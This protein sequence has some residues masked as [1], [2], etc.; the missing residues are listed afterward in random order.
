MLKLGTFLPSSLPSIPSSLSS[1]SRLS[2]PSLRT[3]AVLAFLCLTS[4]ACSYK[5]YQHTVSSPA[6]TATHEVRKAQADNRI[7]HYTTLANGLRVLLISDPAADK[8]AA[9]L[10]VHV[11]SSDDPL[12]RAGLAHFLEHMLFLG[13]EKYPDASEYQAFISENGG[14]HNAYTSAEHTNYFFDVNASKLEEALDRFAQFFVAPLFDEVYVD[15]ERKAVHSEYQAKIKDDYRRGYDVY[16]H[17]M[18]PDHPYSKFSVGSL[19]TLADRP[20]DKVRDDLLDFYQKHYSSDQMTLVV[21]GK[22]SIEE[23]QALVEPRFSPIPQRQVEQQDQFIPLF[24]PGSLPMEVVSNPVQDLRQM[25]MIFP[26]PS[27]KPYYQE[28]PL[29]YL[30]FLLGHEGEGSV[31][32]VL[33]QKGWAES[34]S[35]GG[36]DAGVGNATFHIIVTLTDEGLRHRAE[37]RSLVFHALDVIRKEGVEAWRYAEEQQLGEIAF[38]F[39]ENGRA[40]STV[41]QLADQMHEYPISEVISAPYTYKRFDAKLIHQYLEKMTP[42]NLYVSTVAPGLPT[43]KKSY[44][45]NV[46]YAVGPLTEKPVEIAEELTSQYQLPRKNI[47]IPSNIELLPEE[48]Q[49]SDSPAVWPTNTQQL[50][51]WAQQDLSFGVP[52]ADILV[53]VKLPEVSQSVDAA[54]MSHL[55]I[56]MVNDS[57]NE[58]SYPALIAGLSYSVSPNSRGFDIS[59]RGYH[60]KMGVLLDMLTQRLRSPV[61]QEQRFVN[62]R[63]EL[64]R[65]LQNSQKET[66]FRQLL[67][68]LPVTLFEPYHSD[69]AIAASVAKISFDDLNTFAAR[70]LQGSHMQALFYGNIS[71]QLIGKWQADISRLLVDGELTLAH[72]KV[73][74]LPALPEVDQVRTQSLHVDHNDKAVVLYAQGTTDTMQDQAKMVLIRQVLDASFYNQLRTEQ[75]LGY[76]VFLTNMLIKDVPGSAFVV[77]SPSASVAQ[78]QQAITT[79]IDASQNAI[80]EDLSVF[81]DS[82]A[83][84]LLEK[85]QQLSAKASRFWQ[86]ILKGDPSFSYRKR[87]VKEI[88]KVTPAELRDYYQR[89]LLS[90][91][92]LLWFVADKQVA[93]D[94]PPLFTDD[95]PFY[96]YP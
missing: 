89:T 54:A 5:G 76:I 20:G 14:G 86:D 47:F 33:K 13:T 18:N 58:N 91:D 56:A 63:S 11:G 4:V 50:E 88:Y 72:S 93:E 30:G 41:R 74:K 73:L 8:A 6:D 95:A 77:Q 60:D 46:P 66:P 55:L 61:L 38:R 53:R 48:T 17:V 79:F 44:Y 1:L 39:R 26:L 27:I 49:A 43:D 12:D 85:P 3:P 81:K 65:D 67:G 62:I 24:K 42:D 15:R 94:S 80:P 21:L 68:S 75:Q 36:G 35:A 7:Y 59:L 69:K 19:T 70:W 51:L 10:D 32:S 84:Q 2:L 87:L 25:A 57:L 52:K 45:Y 22:E 37:I 9:S 64:L 28:K 23:L 90:N 82:A 40:I 29:N 92:Q 31:L 34:L 96:P 16:R 78:V 83:T 71:Q